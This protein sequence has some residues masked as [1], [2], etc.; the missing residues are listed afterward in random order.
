VRPAGEAEHAL[1]EALS[2]A[3][4]AG[5]GDATPVDDERVWNRIEARIAARPVGRR[6]AAAGPVLARPRRWSVTLA[7]A[8]VACSLGWLTW[9]ERVSWEARGVEMSEVRLNLSLWHPEAMVETAAVDETEELLS[10]LG[11][12]RS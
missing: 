8:L 7:T 10:L 2:R 1:T 11:P 12:E 3:C 9:G 6:W 4:K 5:R